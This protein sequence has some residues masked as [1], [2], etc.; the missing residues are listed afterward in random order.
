MTLT[1]RQRAKIN[2]ALCM[3]H[4]SGHDASTITA[5]ARGMM[6]GGMEPR[7]AYQRALNR[8]AESVPGML[9][10]LQRVV[11]L[12]EAS[13]DATVAKYDVAISSYI[14]TG[15]DTAMRSL[16]PIIAKDMTEL[17]NRNGQ[18]PPTFSDEFQ[19]MAAQPVRQMFAFED[20]PANPAQAETWTGHE[21]AAQSA[22]GSPKVRTASQISVGGGVT[23][24]VAPKA[25]QEWARVPYVG[26]LSMS[27]PP[28]N[29]GTYASARE[30]ARMSAA[31]PSRALIGEAVG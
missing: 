23:G 19:A 6:G 20:G 11:G 12:V 25:Q 3:I 15:D 30:A 1:V 28:V 7:L 16:A 10:N 27:L 31:M 29:N 26:G 9:P 5:L 14:E 13:D 4:D 22:T 8:F 17:A 18:E 21:G 24:M 2:A